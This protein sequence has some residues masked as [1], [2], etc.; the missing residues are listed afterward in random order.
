VPSSCKAL[1]V[2][3]LPFGPTIGSTQPKYLM[4][5]ESSFRTLHYKCID[6]VQLGQRYILRPFFHLCLSDYFRLTNLPLYS[7]VFLFRLIQ[8][9]LN[10]L[11][12]TAILCGQSSSHRNH[13]IQSG[14]MSKASL[15]YRC[16][17]MCI[18]PIWTLHIAQ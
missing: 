16:L 6:S 5:L 14:Q 11:M 9:C 12:L 17:Q 13:R 2:S 10:R 15:C 18:K 3:V 4:K 1:V 7:I 8:S